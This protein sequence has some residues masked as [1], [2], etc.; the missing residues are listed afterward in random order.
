MNTYQ[1]CTKWDKTRSQVCSREGDK[2]V[3]LNELS[4]D[5]TVLFRAFPISADNVDII[6]VD[7]RNLRRVPSEGSGGFFIPKKK[8]DEEVNLNRHKGIDY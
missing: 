6:T 4:R 3:I 8:D 7:R 5:T 2:G 1:I